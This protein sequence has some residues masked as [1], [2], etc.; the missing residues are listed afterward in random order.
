MSK[1]T[2]DVKYVAELARLRLPEESIAKLQQDME[3]I[4]S[5]IEELNEL[6]V[7][8]IEPTAHASL[9]SNVYREDV[10]QEPFGRVM[11]KNAPELVNEETIKVPRILPGEGSN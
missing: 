3:N 8:E 7:A 1:Q 9:L 10:A 2:I 6:D 11:L 5:Y 4:I